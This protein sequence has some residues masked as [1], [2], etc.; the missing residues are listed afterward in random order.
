[1][2]YFV[3]MSKLF[4]NIY[5]ISIC[6]SGISNACFCAEAEIGSSSMKV[7][8]SRLQQVFN[9]QLSD[10]D[11]NN[12]IDA[13]LLSYQLL[14]NYLEKCIEIK[15][16]GINE[17]ELLDILNET[18]CKLN[19]IT[20]L[21]E[22][23]KNINIALFKKTGIGI[24]TFPDSNIFDVVSTASSELIHGI[25]HSDDM[26]KLLRNPYT[27][28]QL[29]LIIDTRKKR[30]IIPKLNINKRARSVA[31]TAQNNRSVRARLESLSIIDLPQKP[32]F[33]DAENTSE[34][35]PASISSPGI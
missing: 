4:K 7:Y 3:N 11:E 32:V 19:E 30:V 24:K 2:C 29:K 1:M 5:I 10:I 25:L 16:E 6:L 12:P 33:M 18:N 15:N 20:Q 23:V 22:V 17:M 34:L 28:I 8:F 21:S 27:K 13:T 31:A 14:K 35:I 9:S 26:L